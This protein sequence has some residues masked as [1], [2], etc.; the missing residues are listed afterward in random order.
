E[1]VQDSGNNIIYEI[2]LTSC[3]ITGIEIINGEIGDSVTFQVLDTIDGTVTTIPNFVL[4]EFGT[5][6]NVAEK[7]YKHK[8]PYDADLFAGLQLKLIYDAVN[9]IAAKT[10]GINFILDEVK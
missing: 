3:K 2:P 8:S 10:I 7:L 5:N 6:V 9:T 4:N 1:S